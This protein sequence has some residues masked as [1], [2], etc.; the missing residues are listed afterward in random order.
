MDKSLQSH[1]SAYERWSLLP[2]VLFLLV[3]IGC[4]LYFSLF[5]DA[6]GFHS[7]P[8]VMATLP[9]IALAI[10]LARIFKADFIKTFA[11][12]ALNKNVLLM[13][14]IFALSGMF[15]AV[16]EQSG[17]V[18]ATVNLGL[19]V[20]PAGFL[21]AG[22][23]V[24][25]SLMSTAMGTSVGTVAALSAIALGMAGEA[26]IHLGLMA[27]VLISGAMFG[28]NLSL[29][30]DTSVAATSTQDCQ[31]RE[32]FLENFKIVV[33][34][35]VGLFLIYWVMS[36]GAPLNITPDFSVW[37]VVPYLM[38]F[39]LALL[40]VPVLI[41]LV[42]GCLIAGFLGIYFRQITMV[43]LPGV[44][45]DGFMSLLDFMLLSLA[46]SGLG[47]LVEKSGGLSLIQNAV[48]ESV[49]NLMKKKTQSQKTIGE[50]AIAVLVSLSNLATANNTI[51]I[52]LSGVAARSI[53]EKTK[54]VKKRA[55]S[56]LDIFS[57]VIQGVIP[58]GMQILIISAVFKI[59]PMEISLYAFYPWCLLFV[60]LFNIWSSDKFRASG[61]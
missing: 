10:V 8:P 30:S 37:M 34:A 42:V 49:S 38:I 48:M 47:M 36:P 24:L 12:G 41:V 31:P 53:A 2:L 20:M 19:S 44:Y 6:K 23:F 46:I 32:K 15:S 58:W 27:G 22:F 21:L 29:I 35:A 50:L 26:D 39:I 59:S 18:K 51:A 14:A 28:D 43:D 25:S 3:F 1:P 9:S 16:A 7:F 5:G 33:P 13:C 40:G 52:L 4:G 60:A 61:S 55:A 57:C 45:F 11:A 17:C 54:I 56:I